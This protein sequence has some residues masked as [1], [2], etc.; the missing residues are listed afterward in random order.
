M[1]SAALTDAFKSDEISMSDKLSI[2]KLQEKDLVALYRIREIA[3][4]DNIS[5]TNE[6]VQA[7]HRALLEYQYGRF[8]GD[9]LLSSARWYPFSAF[10]DGRPQ[11]IGG[12]A[13]VV[14]A[15]ATRG[16]GH[17][18]ALLHH[19]LERL[20]KEGIAW[21]L[22]YPFDTRYYRKYGWETVANGQCFDVP[23]ARFSRFERPTKVRRIIAFNE[24]D[25]AQLGRIHQHWASAYNFTM[26]RDN[27]VRHDWE[28]VLTGA[29]W[30]PVERPRF[31]FAT[32]HAYAVVM[33][34]ESKDLT[35][36]IL[37]DFAFE[38]PRGR[39]ELFGFINHFAGQADT[40]RLQLPQ[41]DPL[42]MEWS[43]FGIAHPHPLH[44]RIVDAAAALSG[45]KSRAP[46]DFRLGI[47]DDFCAWNNAVFQVDTHEQKTRATPVNMPAEVELDVRA[48]AQILS[49]SLTESAARRNGLVQGEPEAISILCGLNKLPCYMSMADYF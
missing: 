13:S 21:S 9:E 35:R 15:A 17:V 45:W 37:S 22:E 14:S 18:R 44:A 5:R 2:R 1:P 32:D 42:T 11:K 12:L 8:R 36:L 40:V 3:F 33:L 25:M 19:G 7:Q 23:I 6:K 47:R 20:H 26:T 34:R 38:T 27:R 39:Q 28:Y 41:D 48:L 46:V 4:L 49:G 29:P 24:A 31:V 10:V 43:N 30:A 16:Q